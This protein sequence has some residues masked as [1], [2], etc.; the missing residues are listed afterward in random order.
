M[1]ADGRGTS[2]LRKGLRVK[3]RNPQLVRWISRAI[4]IGGR[5]L[6]STARVELLS[7]VAHTLPN[8]RMKRPTHLYCAWHDSIAALLFQGP[9]LRMAG[10]T[11]RHADGSIVSEVM[12]AL[13]IKPVRGSTR[14]GGAAALAELIK[15]SR[16]YDIAITSDGPRGPRRTMKDGIVFL[17]SVTGLSIVPVTFSCRDAWRPRGRWTDM[18]IPKPLARGWL[19]TGVPIDVPSRIDRVRVRGCCDQLQAVM[20]EQQAFGDTI[21]NGSA[22]RPPAGFASGFYRSGDDRPSSWRSVGVSTISDEP[23]NLRAFPHETTQTK[24]AA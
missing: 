6:F 8:D 4:A 10:L 18:T 24:R 2:P 12:A 3:L 20:D 15:V 17:A 14:H 16:N 5:G 11:S 21:A 9:A 23:A 19:L 13:D 7:A 1:C 22:A